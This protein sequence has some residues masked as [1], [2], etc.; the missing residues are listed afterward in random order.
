MIMATKTQTVTVEHP[1]AHQATQRDINKAI[2][3]AEVPEE[4]V[5]TSSV[6]ES[7][8]ST[9]LTLEW[10]GPEETKAKAASKS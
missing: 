3:E 4:A 7:G 6:N 8:V 2:R 9:K 1:G 5:V 10:D